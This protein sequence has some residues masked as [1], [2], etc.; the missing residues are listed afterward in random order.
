MQYIDIRQAIVGRGNFSLSPE[1]KHYEV[2]PHVWA[3]KSDDEK[4][5]LVATFVTKRKY[6]VLQTTLI[7]STDKLLTIPYKLSTGK[8]PG[9][10]KRTRAERTKTAPRPTKKTK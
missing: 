9:Q 4:N 10:R 8:K 6:K 3:S 7:V 2:H 1:Y 5:S